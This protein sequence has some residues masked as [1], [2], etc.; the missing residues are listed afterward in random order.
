MP[1]IRKGLNWSRL[2]EQCASPEML[3]TAVHDLLVDEKTGPE[4]KQEFSLQECA[5]QL[6]RPG[7]DTTPLIHGFMEAVNTSQFSVI[8]SEL[9]SSAVLDG[10]NNTP[11]ILPKL[12][13]DMPSR[14]QIDKV[15]GAYVTGELDEVKEGMPYNEDADIKDKY[16]TAEGAKRGKTLNVT[17]EAVLFD[18]TGL[19]M[20][21][22]G[23]L[24]ELAAMDQE[25]RGIFHILDLANYKSWR[26]SGTQADL[27][28]N[29]QGAGDPHEYDN[30]ITNALA[31]WTDLDAA[32]K[33]LGTM[34]DENGN[35]IVHPPNV[36]LVP[37][38]LDTMARRLIGN[39]VL[40]GASNSEQNPFYNSV[41][42]LSSPF[43]DISGDTNATTLWLYGNFKRQFKNKVVIPLQ[44]RRR[45]FTDN[46]DPAFERDIFAQINVRHYTEVFATDYRYVI[47]SSGTA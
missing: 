47:K 19:V 16:V 20:M 17:E 13:Q 2:A 31:D 4:I 24:G 5:R 40:T 15:P 18:Q 21:R 27:W 35:P 7:M 12:V 28:Q 37:N 39:K 22:A 30:L 33:L 6:I 11:R 25:K 44:I 41:E 3:Q 8:S 1:V 45:R 29:A 38:A 34:R 32:K 10:F 43:I 9:L 36:L 46:H 42:P 26:P 14:L 23:E